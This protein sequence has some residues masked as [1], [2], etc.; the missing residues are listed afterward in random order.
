MAVRIREATVAD[1]RAIAEVHVEG[2]SWGYRD[3]LPDDV[4]ANRTIGD[5]EA[6]WIRGFTEDWRDGD[7]CF[8]AEDD[9]GRV[10]GFVACGP[11]ADEHHVAPAGTGEVY[12][13]YLREAVVGTGVGRALF[14]RAEEALTANGF[15]DAVLWVLEDNVRARR[16]YESAGWA[17]DGTRGAH[18]FDCA[19]RPL[20]RYRRQTAGS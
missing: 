11:A 16:F 5:R 19:N 2:W 18:R 10:V 6:E 20:V 14:A 3:L 1:A 17:F 8:V 15:D 13:I 12:S 9:D 4:I 7:A